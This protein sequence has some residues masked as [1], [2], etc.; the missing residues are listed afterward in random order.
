MTLQ[1]AQA[2][3]PAAR[4]TAEDLLA[5]LLIPGDVAGSGALTAGLRCFSGRRRGS[6][7]VS[8]ERGRTW[9]PNRPAAGHALQ[10]HPVSRNRRMIARSRRS[11]KPCRNSPPAGAAH[12]HREVP[13]PACRDLRRARLAM[14]D[15][16]F[17]PPC[18]ASQT[19]AEGTGSASRQTMARCAQARLPPG[20]PGRQKYAKLSNAGGVWCGL[21]EMLDSRDA[22][23]DAALPLCTI[24]K[25]DR[26]A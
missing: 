26:E 25:G 1:D 10:P 2:Q 5:Q 15:R 13:E 6:A 11:R 21:A 17:R 14:G 8:T 12:P 16:R 4:V 23:F 7:P 3:P 19:A 18:P 9:I 20:T 22:R 24:R